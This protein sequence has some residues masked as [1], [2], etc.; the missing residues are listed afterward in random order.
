[1]TALCLPDICGYVSDPKSSSVRDRYANWFEQY[2]HEKYHGYMSG[3]EAYALRCIVLHNGE[4]ITKQYTLRS[5]EIFGAD[6]AFQK[7]GMFHA[8]DYSK[9]F[10]FFL[11][12][13]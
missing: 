4:L 1:M 8:Y 6:N 11:E 7:C 13:L 2:M 10:I 5:K 12:R 9:L 3:E